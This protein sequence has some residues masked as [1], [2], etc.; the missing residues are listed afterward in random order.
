MLIKSY[1][2]YINKCKY[3]RHKYKIKTPYRNDRV[4]F[5][6]P[7]LNV[8]YF[9]ILIFYV[10]L[11]VSP[12]FPHNLKSSPVILNKIHSCLLAILLKIRSS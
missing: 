11:I 9:F 1:E 10:F 6:I 8:L 4:F 5:N 7:F 3:S 12:Y 2:Y